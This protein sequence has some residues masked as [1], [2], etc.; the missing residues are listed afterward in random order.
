MTRHLVNGLEEFERPRIQR[1]RMGRGELS[2]LDTTTSRRIAVRSFF[3]ANVRQEGEDGAGRLLADARCFGQKRQTP[4]TFASLESIM[5]YKQSF[6]QSE[7]TGT[8]T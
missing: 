4:Q 8:R 2:L 5:I 7:E 6:A 1:D 3:S